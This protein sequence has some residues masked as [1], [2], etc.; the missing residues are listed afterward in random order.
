MANNGLLFRIAHIVDA[1][2]K[3]LTVPPEACAV[4]HR[5]LEALRQLEAISRTSFHAQV[6][7]HAARRVEGESSQDLLL[8]YLFAFTNFA[9]YRPDLDAIDRA[10]QSA[11]IAC[12]A[13]GA[14]VFGIQI[15]PRRA[16]ESLGY[17][18][19]LEWI[20]LRVDCLV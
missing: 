18:S 17:S 9:A 2:L 3:H 12:Y 19:R 1:L 6:A 14:P 16:A 5:K 10:G 15:Q 11:K 13:Q 20:L 7:K 4:V 8:V